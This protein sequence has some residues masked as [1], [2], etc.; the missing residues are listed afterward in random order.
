MIVRSLELRRTRNAEVDDLGARH[1]AARDH[2]VVGRDVAVDDAALV[3]R[4]QP[5]GDALEQCTHRLIGQRPS[6]RMSSASD[7]P[8]T[9]SIARYG[10]PSAGSMVKT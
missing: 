7:C 3:R 4:M 6:R 2:D 9:N 10:R 1:V 5:G 8:S